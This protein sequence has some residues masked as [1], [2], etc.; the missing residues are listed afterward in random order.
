MEY[1][2]LGKTNARVSRAG[3]G[4]APAGLTNYLGAFSPH[5]AQQREQVVAAI[6]EALRLGVTYFDTAAG[7]G[8]GAG[9]EIFG[10]ALRGQREQIFLASKMSPSADK[11]P[12]AM[13]EDSL[14]RLQTDTLDLMQFHG[15]SYTPAM[16]D[17]ILRPGG[18]L[19]EMEKARAEGLV[20]FIGFTTEDQNPP[21]YQ[22][23]ATGRFDVM[24]VCYNLIYQHP[25]EPTRPFGCMYEAERQGMGLVTMRTL[26]SGIFQRWIQW[27][28]PANTFDYTPA[29]LQY[30]LSNPLVDVALVGMRTA[31]EVR[32]TVAIADNL[33]GRVDIG[34]LHE[35]YVKP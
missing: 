17:R 19:D 29:L 33:S 31:E 2:T 12:R 3:F 30:V 25:A 21:V 10:E 4:G 32:A 6:Q 34:A 28:N 7:Y 18:M 11:E 23:I 22:F 35:R 20:R 24:Q 1:T 15:G 9:E 27:A 5:D 13:L 14:K 16:A 8:D 26:T